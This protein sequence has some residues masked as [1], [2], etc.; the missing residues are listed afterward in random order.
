M[1]LAAQADA[2]VARELISSLPLVAHFWS[3]G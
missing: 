1:V 3:H 2:P